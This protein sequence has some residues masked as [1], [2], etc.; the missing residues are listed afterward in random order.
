MGIVAGE[1]FGVN[2]V[3]SIK[4][5]PGGVNFIFQAVIFRVK[6]YNGI[7]VDEPKIMFN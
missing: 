5:D 6:F 4:F 2:G 1:S 7:K 3:I